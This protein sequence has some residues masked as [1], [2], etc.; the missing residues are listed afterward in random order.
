MPDSAA[1]IEPADIQPA[2]IDGTGVQGADARTALLAD[3][4]R[5]PTTPG[6]PTLPGGPVGYLMRATWPA[7]WRRI[8]G[9]WRSTT[10]AQPGQPGWRRSRSG[11]P[12]SRPGGRRGARWWRSGPA[13]MQPFPAALM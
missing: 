8:T 12:S 6:W 3:A 9:T 11:M 2:D 1:D 4:T 7:T 10:W 13:A 5:R